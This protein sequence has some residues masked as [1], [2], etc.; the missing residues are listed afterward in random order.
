MREQ[1][2]LVP[3]AESTSSISSDRQEGIRYDRWRFR[4][5]SDPSVLRRRALLKQYGSVRPRRRN[6]LTKLLPR[7]CLVE[8]LWSRRQRRIQSAYAVGADA[9]GHI[10]TALR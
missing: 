4:P 9:V 6:R 8:L 1:R 5:T 2:K 7:A 10:G 3:C